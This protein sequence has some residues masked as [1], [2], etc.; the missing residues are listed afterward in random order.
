LFEFAAAKVYKKN[1]C[2]YFSGD[3]FY[4]EGKQGAVLNIYLKMI[5]GLHYGKA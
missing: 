4:N 2:I 5:N 3:I 1:Q